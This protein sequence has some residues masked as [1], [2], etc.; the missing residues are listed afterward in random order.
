MEYK[1]FETERLY[2]R[3]TNQDDAAFIFELM[4][5]EKWLQHIGDRNI[6]SV[7]DAA[8]YIQSKMTP[9]LTKLGYGNYTLITKND[10]QKVGTCGLYD[11]EGLE[12][13]DIGF[14]FLPEYE[15]QGLAYEAAETIKNAAFTDF[16][17]NLIQAITTKDNMAS[18]RLLEKLGLQVSGT[19]TLPD[20]TEEL[21]VYKIEKQS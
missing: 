9:Q 12:G 10:Q 17:M 5:T 1:T 15:K 6:K 3:P 14:A 2:I 20:D 16:G 11:R 19:T 21:L 4:N 8:A 7:E 18:Q 13:I